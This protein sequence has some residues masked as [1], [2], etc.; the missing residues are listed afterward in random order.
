MKVVH[1]PGFPTEELNL[2]IPEDRQVLVD[3]ARLN[4]R[5]G[6]GSTYGGSEI[7][8]MD[9]VKVLIATGGDGINGVIQFYSSISE[10][11]AAQP[12]SNSLAMV[13]SGLDKD[14][15][16]WRSGAAVP[17]FGDVASSID[18]R[19]S[20]IT[21]DPAVVYQ[22]YSVGLL[23]NLFV[24]IAAPGAL[25]PKTPWLDTVNG[26]LKLW[27]GAAYVAANTDLWIR[28][29]MQVGTTVSITLAD[30]T[31]ALPSLGFDS[32]PDTG[33]YYNAGTGLIGFTVDSGTK[34]S[35]AADM[36]FTGVPVGVP[37]G[38]AALPTFTFNGDTDTGLYRYGTNAIGIAAAGVNVAAFS[39]NGFT[40]AA[41]YQIRAADGLVA[42]PGISFAADVDTGIFRHTTNILGVSIGG[43]GIAYFGGFASSGFA[44]DIIG[45]VGITGDLYVP[46]IFFGP[47]NLQTISAGAVTPEG[48]VTARVG[49][50]YVNGTGGATTTLYVKTTGT[51]NTGWTAK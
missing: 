40:M 28:Y 14:I 18:G 22:L 25:Q 17:L 39:A 5:I 35:I 15:F 13:R 48:S 44:L 37:I 8:N 12:S 26:I 41:T 30:G 20:R 51:G 9:Q 49:S 6:D 46:R 45:T 23:T 47:V 24:G 50:L 33:M 32:N 36:L 31:V 3:T 4:L 19:W 1:F 38:S 21:E 11:A 27:N 29:L 43:N 7:P 16:Y 34:L 10:L 2:L 42:T